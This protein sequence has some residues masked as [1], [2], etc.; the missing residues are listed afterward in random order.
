MIPD[1]AEVRIGGPH[2]W[3]EVMWNTLTVSKTS[4]PASF[5]VAFVF[6]ECG[7]KS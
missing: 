3:H 7:T 2:G 4:T 1:V 6:G 5:S